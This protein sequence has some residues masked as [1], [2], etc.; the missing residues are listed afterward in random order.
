MI[1]AMLL[2][3]Q[4]VMLTVLVLIA[5]AAAGALG[6]IIGHPPRDGNE[7]VEDFQDDDADSAT[8]KKS[9]SR[10]NS[11]SK[12]G[13]TGTKRKSGSALIA[14]PTFAPVTTPTATSGEVEIPDGVQW[15][16]PALPE[17][18]A[19]TVINVEPIN[20]GVIKARSA[21]TPVR[22]DEMA[23][24]IRVERPKD[25]SEPFQQPSPTG[26]GLTN[27]TRRAPSSPPASGPSPTLAPASPPSPARQRRRGQLD[28]TLDDLTPEELRDQ[29]TRAEVEM[30]RIE[31]NALAAWDRTVPAL[32]DRI[33]QLQEDNAQLAAQ[34]SEL[35]TLTSNQSEGP[36]QRR[37]SGRTR[38]QRLAGS[39]GRS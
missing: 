18:Y 24:A 33:A 9:S 5:V 16:P 39:D 4:W 37:R 10:R 3:N 28:P 6:W 38:E 1:E 36:P 34:V 15:S 13:A 20:A 2:I 29:L 22:P 21:P 17:E 11:G 26:H 7:E 8:P 25:A 23:P 14:N 35:R 19:A 30:G 27:P 32:Q 12:K 31:A